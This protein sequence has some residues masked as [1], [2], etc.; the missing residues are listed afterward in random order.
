MRYGR[1]Q[2]VLKQKNKPLII[3][4]EFGSTY[5]GCSAGGSAPR[6]GRGGRWFES[7]HPDYN[8]GLNNKFINS[9]KASH[10]P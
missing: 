9:F 1:V 10:S 4:A 2:K 7:S 8:F 3:F 5:T 6:S